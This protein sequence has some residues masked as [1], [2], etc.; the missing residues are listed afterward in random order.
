MAR[1]RA[2]HVEL[3]VD[4]QPRGDGVAQR[5]TARHGFEQRMLGLRQSFEH[6][7]VGT[8][9]H[10]NPFGAGVDLHGI[11]AVIRH[12]RLVCLPDAQD[13]VARGDEPSRRL[14]SKPQRQARLVGHR[15]DAHERGGGV[16][17]RHALGVECRMPGPVEPGAVGQVRQRRGRLE[18]LEEGR[19]L[20]A[21]LMQVSGARRVRDDERMRGEAEE[22]LADQRGDRRVHRGERTGEAVEDV[23]AMDVEAALRRQPVRHDVTGRPVRAFPERIEHVGL[24]LTQGRHGTAAFVGRSPLR[25]AAR[26]AAGGRH[27]TR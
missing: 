17:G 20:A 2:G 9:H 1:H 4:R 24:K 13:G 21:E 18:L 10:E 11:A 23:V 12:R 16:R 8:L 22:A 26:A 14:P 5:R 19:Q 6:D 15:G 25:R 27:P 7:S 3:R